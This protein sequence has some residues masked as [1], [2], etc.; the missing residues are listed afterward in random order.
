MGLQTILHRQ[1]YFCQSSAIC[2]LFQYLTKMIIYVV[3]TGMSM[4]KMLCLCGCLNRKV[5]LRKET[6]ALF[7]LEVCFFQYHIGT[8]SR[9]PFSSFH[10]KSSVSTKLLRE[11]KPHIHVC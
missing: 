7:V 4:L 1:N 3:R 9:S 10:G 2:L 11:T 6:S 8:E 5:A